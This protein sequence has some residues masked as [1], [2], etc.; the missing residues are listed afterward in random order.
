MDQGIQKLIEERLSTTVQS[1]NRVSG[2][3]IN[4]AFRIETVNGRFF[5]KINASVNSIDILKSEQYGL[6]VLRRTSKVRVPRIVDFLVH[7]KTGILIL[8]WITRGHSTRDAYQDLGR[9]LAALHTC[10]DNQFGSVPD[11]FIGALPQ[12]NTS[13]DDF[14]TF[15]AECRILPQ[16]KMAVDRDVFS[17]KTLN[18]FKTFLYKIPLL[19]PKENPVLI[20]GDLWGGNHMVNDSG[21][22]YIIDPSISYNHREMDL[23]MMGLFGGYPEVTYLTYNERLPLIP[24]WRERADI[25]Q[26][27]YLLVHLNLFGSGY[28]NSVMRILN[29]YL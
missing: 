22:P 24:G 20:H 17:K 12:K 14:E 13:Y 8:E 10:R 25:F 9:Q 27:Y 16:V 18:G 5:V 15:Y 1:V 19:I 23:A 11:N 2:G 26:L 29:K 21:H 7:D 4:E 28:Y 6:D 3:D